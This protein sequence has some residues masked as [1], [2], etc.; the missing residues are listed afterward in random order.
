MATTPRKN[1]TGTSIADIAR[2]AGVSSSTV[3][4]ALNNNPAINITTREKIQ[5]IARELNYKVNTGARNL[6]LQR[7]H[8]IALIINA[9]K[10]D[11]QTF[12]DPFMMDMIGAIADELNE[13]QYSLLYSSSAIKPQD[14]CSHLLSSQRADGVIVIGQGRNDEPLRKLQQESNAVVAWGARLDNANYCIVGSD[15][16]L[17]GQLATRHLIK[18]GCTR[19]LFLGDVEHPEIERRFHGYFDALAEQGLSSRE[20]HVQ[21]AFSIESGYQHVIELLTKGLDFDGIFAASD[22]IA[23][24]AI[25]ALREKGLRVPLDVA[26]VGFDDIPIAP[27][28]NPPLTSVRQ[29][30]HLGGKILV[31]KVMAMVKGQSVTSEIIKTE[32]VVRSS[33]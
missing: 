28:F 8:T 30:V 23:M 32:L 14:W 26:V 1:P 15:N 7:S 6:R 33:S 22:N 24:G 29:N 17:G 12:S 21:S 18:R 11:G 16:Y 4:R 10:V 27:Y 31:Q 25:N 5:A 2:R 20:H 3:S 19:M 13:H 9:E